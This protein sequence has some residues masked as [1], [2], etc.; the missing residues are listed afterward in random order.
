MTELKSFLIFGE[1]FSFN[2]LMATFDTVL[3]P[4]NP[5][6]SPLYTF[7]NAPSPSS[8][9]NRTEDNMNSLILQPEAFPVRGTV[10]TVEFWEEFVPLLFAPLSFFF[11]H[12]HTTAIRMIKARGTIIPGTRMY[13]NLFT[14]SAPL[15]EIQKLVRQ[16][17]QDKCNIDGKKG[18]CDK[19][20]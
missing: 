4:Y 19:Y 7:P 20:I 14:G 13:I 16:L 5:I 11:W 3:S 18:K 12:K 17:K 9:R 10:S 1:A 15:T 2:V 6:T 8:C